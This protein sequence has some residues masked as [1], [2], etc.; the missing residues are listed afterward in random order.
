MPT[1]NQRAAVAADP[2]TAEATLRELAVDQSPKVRTAVAGNPASP[3]DVLDSLAN[4]HAWQ[5]RFAVANNRSPQAIKSAANSRYSDVR[6]LASQRD[7]LDDTTRHRLLNDPDHRV[8]ISM[9]EGCSDPETLIA[10]SRDDRDD[11]RAAVVFNN[12]LPVAVVEMLAGDRRAGVRAA[13]AAS[14][15][16]RPDTLTRLASDRSAVVRWQVIFHNAERQDLLELLSHDPDEFNA[17]HARAHLAESR[18]TTDRER[19]PD[20]ELLDRLQQGYRQTHGR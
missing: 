9:A 10:L 8:R 20:P 16:V 12:Y 7:N 6:G 15:R 17:D 5:P 19:M 1:I 3:P 18:A 13:V 4:D 2:N 11:V 14:R